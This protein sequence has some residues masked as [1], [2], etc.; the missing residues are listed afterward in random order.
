[1]TNHILQAAL[2]CQLQPI[3]QQNTVVEGASTNLHSSVYIN[4]QSILFNYPISDSGYVHLYVSGN[5]FYVYLALS[6]KYF[7]L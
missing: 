4:F 2:S 3:S 7:P 1:M 5:L 6:H